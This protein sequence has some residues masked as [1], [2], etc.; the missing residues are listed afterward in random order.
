MEAMEVEAV[1]DAGAARLGAGAAQPAGRHRPAGSRPD[2]DSES[3]E[4]L[5]E[6]ELPFA[7]SR[8]RAEM[9]GSGRL[10]RLVVQHFP[11]KVIIKFA[12]YLGIRIVFEIPT[13]ILWNRSIRSSSRT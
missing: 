5:L 8:L 11:G 9:A 1:P 6:W 4:D 13:K 2:V 12:Q 7:A 10:G 3:M